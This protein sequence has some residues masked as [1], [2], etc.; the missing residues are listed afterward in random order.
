MWAYRLRS[1]NGEG[2]DRPRPLIT[3]AIWVG[4]VL[5][6]NRRGTVTRAQV[7]SN[8]GILHLCWDF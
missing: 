8:I 7:S 6:E 2:G 5:A 1:W 3:I 4:F